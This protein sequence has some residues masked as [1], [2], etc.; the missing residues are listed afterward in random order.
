MMMFIDISGSYFIRWF[1]GAGLCYYFFF[2][3]EIKGTS[4]TV[5]VV[6]Y[7]DEMHTEIFSTLIRNAI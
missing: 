1:D 3:S 7:S 2:F 4:G 5:P 6:S